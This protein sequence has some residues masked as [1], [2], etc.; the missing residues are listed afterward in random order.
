[1][2]R[3]LR[4]RILI[5]LFLAAVVAFALVRLSGRQPVAKISAVSPIRENVI[6]SI[7]SNGKVESIAPFIVRAQLDTF[8][9][10]I[11]A[12]EGQTV[13]KGQL[14]LELNVKDAAAQLA[15]ARSKLLRAEDDLRAAQAGGRSDEAAKTEGQLAAAIALRD[16]LQRNHDS[17]QRLITQQAATKDE[18]AVNDL[19]LAK[20]DDQVKQLTA[21]KQEFVRGVKLDA[22][23][24]SLQVEQLRS[25]VASLEG[26]VRDGRIAAPADGTLYSLPAKAGDYVKVGDLLAEMADLHKVRVRAFIDEPELG[27]LEPGEPVRIT[28]DALPNR[29]W[30]G[31]T[32]VIPKQVVARGARSVGELLCEVDNDKLELLPNINVNVR[33]NSHERINVLT[34]PRGTV[35]GD[36]GQRFVFVVLRNALGVGK[37]TLQK[38]EIRVGIADATNY[39]V[40]SGLQEGEMVALPGDVDLKDGMP[41]RIVNTDASFIRGRSESN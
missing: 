5:F 22:N 34:V 41:V 3:R 33:I 31:K 9:E 26:K 1:M 17:L 11:S 40:L 23:R 4:N 13:K 39:E 18:L 28:W 12:V 35:E 7:S 37:A 20:A 6:S 10:R 36:G 19:E 24:T 27:G 14:L 8:I 15:D 30:M 32:Q 25:Q 16:R 2:D 29:T 21:A 38:R